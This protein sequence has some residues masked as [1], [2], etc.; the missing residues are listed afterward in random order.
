MRFV[1][2][3]ISLIFR[4]D[5]LIPFL[6]IASYLSLVFIAK[7]SIPSSEEMIGLFSELYA[8]YGYEIIFISAF[9]E[10]L[11]I[12]SLVVPGTLALA[13]GIIFARTGQTDLTLVILTVIAGALLGY[14][15]DYTL[16]YLGF[17]DLLKKL[18]YGKFLE[19][20]KQKLSKFKKRGLIIGFIHA[21]FGSFLSFSAGA[22]GYSFP[23]FLLVASLATIAWTS[24]WSIIIYSLGD[25][26][27]EILKRY[28]F[29]FFMAVLAVLFLSQ[30]WNRDKENN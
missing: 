3:L 20:S 8:K 2:R 26:V 21:N 25:I 9:L 27:L 19:Q 6:L 29:L 23:T 1:W 4:L 5:L 10:S 15:L 12:I 17:S 30:I 22:T 16:G 7:G 18:G 14:L 24:F 28:S 13:L 11:I